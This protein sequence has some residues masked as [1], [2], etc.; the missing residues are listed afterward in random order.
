MAGELVPLVMLPRYS[1]YNGAGD[2]TT[3]GM[4]VTDYTSAI[5]N[6]WR[7][8]FNGSGTVAFSCEESTDQTNW[9]TC[10][11]TNVAGYDPGQNN[12][13]QAVA[14]LKKRWFRVKVAVAGTGA[15]GVTCWAIGFLEQRE[16]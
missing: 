15:I 5:L 6:V 3:I 13:G 11:G 2:F 10:S 4:E 16:A 9:T 1:S 7:G 8:P 14:T 12:E